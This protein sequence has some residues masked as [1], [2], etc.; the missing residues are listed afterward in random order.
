MI[1]SSVAWI[2]VHSL[3]WNYTC[4][5]FTFFHVLYILHH[6][7][8]PKAQ[9]LEQHLSEGFKIMMTRSLHDGWIHS[10]SIQSSIF[11]ASFQQRICSEVCELLVRK[12]LWSLRHGSDVN[13]GYNHLHIKHHETRCMV[14]CPVPYNVDWCIFDWCVVRCGLA[15]RHSKGIMWLTKIIGLHSQI[16]LIILAQS[17][18][19]WLYELWKLWWK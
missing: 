5:F 17:P 12:G 3:L 8:W 14:C 6:V 18:T 19:Y 2:G 11:R 10:L 16:L 4:S 9:S 15:N 1:T 7:E 13:W